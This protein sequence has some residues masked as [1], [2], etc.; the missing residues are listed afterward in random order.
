MTSSVIHMSFTGVYTRVAHS[1]H[2]FMLAEEL[3]TIPLN[4]K[5]I[6]Y[7]R[8]RI[9]DLFAR[10]F[11][12]A[13]ILSRLIYGTVICSY[14]FRAVPKFIQMASNLGDTTSI[15]FI[16]AQVL[17]FVLTRILNLYWTILIVRKL[18]IALGS[19]KS[20][21]SINNVELNKKAL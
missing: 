8:P 12:A 20:P 7:Q 16:I 2:F 11:V 15:V 10:L 4:L 21:V 6:Y 9:R 17:L 3:S 18:N 1:S 19:N 14:T 13:F 5:A